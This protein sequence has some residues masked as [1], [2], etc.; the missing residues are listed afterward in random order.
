MTYSFKTFFVNDNYTDFDGL[1]LDWE[2]PAQRGSPST[3]KQRF[4]FL[5]HEMKSAFQ[6]HGLLLTAAVAAGQQSAAKSYEILE[7]SRSLDFINL[8]AYDLH[9]SWESVTGHQTD[10]NPTL[11]NDQLSVINAVRYWLLSGMDSTKLILG[12]GTYGRS[13]TLQ[14]RCKSD[15]GDKVITGG[16]A[17]PYTNEAGFLA[18]HEICNLKWTSKTCTKKSSAFA[19][20][21][22]VGTLFVG[23]DDA[24]SLIFKV[25]EI[26]K[27][28]DLG[29]I[30][31]WALDLDDFK[32]VCGE[33]S[34]P[35]IKTANAALLGS[36]PINAK[37]C[38]DI[39][40]QSCST[41]S[42][43]SMPLLGERINCRANQN[44]LLGSRDEIKTY[45]RMKCRKDEK[46]CDQLCCCDQRKF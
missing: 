17:G 8:M 23:Y 31:F 18:Y 46:C 11:A 26:V 38:M 35:L 22:S 24:E 43:C 28:F 12:L 7:M 40:D 5:C 39:F 33:G 44:G 16:K 45:C 42:T 25:N 34:Y 19:P 15:L 13:F 14:D 27:K 29:G 3:D 32:G 36:G 9:G 6:A 20:Y 1:D 4:T 30:M 21:G 41:T 10:S 37:P 2:Y